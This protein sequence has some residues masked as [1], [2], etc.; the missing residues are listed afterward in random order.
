MG[1]GTKKGLKKLKG[2]GI[3]E[4]NCRKKM[5]IILGRI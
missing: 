2:D 4:R 1:E 3:G 5:K